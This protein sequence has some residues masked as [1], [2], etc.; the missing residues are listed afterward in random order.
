MTVTWKAEPL[1]GPCFWTSVQMLI[2]YHRER[3]G[4]PRYTEFDELASR[5]LPFMVRRDVVQTQ[6]ER[7]GLQWA[8]YPFVPRTSSS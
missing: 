8:M 7:L 1:R 2:R 6:L 4:L 5:H 3:L